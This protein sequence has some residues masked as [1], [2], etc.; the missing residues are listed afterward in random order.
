MVPGSGTGT[1]PLLL[2]PVPNMPVAVVYQSIEASDRPLTPVADAVDD[3]SV[4]TTV[5]T[6]AVIHRPGQKTGRRTVM[7]SNL[8]VSEF[9]AQYLTG[10]PSEE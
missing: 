10:E 3:V 7:I 2:K 8:K 4:S 6:V 1:Q 9:Y 5:K